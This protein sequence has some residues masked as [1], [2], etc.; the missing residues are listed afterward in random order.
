MYEVTFD[1]RRAHAAEG[2]PFTTLSVTRPDSRT[3]EVII[4]RKNGDR[5]HQHVEA[6]LDGTVLGV[7]ES[8]VSSQGT[9]ANHVSVLA[10]TCAAHVSILFTCPR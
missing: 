3:L 6:S 10:L 7:T 9:L 8:G 2:D 5:L 1:G 4:T